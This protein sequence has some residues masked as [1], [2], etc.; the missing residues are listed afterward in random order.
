MELKNVAKEETK[1]KE[2]SFA[3]IDMDIIDEN[4]YETEDDYP[5]SK[6]G[7]KTKEDV[8]KDAIKYF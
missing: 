7:Y 6:V 3:W 4:D 5:L 8:I 1:N 2:R